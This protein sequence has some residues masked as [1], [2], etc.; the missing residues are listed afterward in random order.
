[1]AIDFVFCS[2]RRERGSGDKDISNIAFVFLNK[3]YISIYSAIC[4]IVDYETKGRNVTRFPAVD[5]EYYLIITLLDILCHFIGEGSVSRVVGAY[6]FPVE[7]KS[8]YMSH[9][10]KAKEYSF[11]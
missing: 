3:K 4:Q 9:S 7:I 2:K 5:F 10:I 8:R 1:M 6:F 11:I